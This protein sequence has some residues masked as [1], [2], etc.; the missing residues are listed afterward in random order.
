LNKLLKENT[1]IEASEIASEET[2][3][4]TDIRASADYRKE[5]SKVWFG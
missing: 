5:L 2:Q 1:I 3:P 4:I